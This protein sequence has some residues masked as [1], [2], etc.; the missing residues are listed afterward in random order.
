MIS[1]TISS[2]VVDA[3]A[4]VAS[5]PASLLSAGQACLSSV[6]VNSPQMGQC[7]GTP[8]ALCRIAPVRS[9]PGQF[10]AATGGRYRADQVPEFV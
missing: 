8:C 7:A 9:A 3:D 6:D 2:V 5:A 4:H 10:M 1:P